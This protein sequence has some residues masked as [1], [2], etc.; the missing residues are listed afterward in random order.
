MQRVITIKN[1]TAED[2]DAEA[3]NSGRYNTSKP[4]K[5][6]HGFG[7]RNIRKTVEKYGGMLSFACEDKEF[8]LTIM[9]M[10]YNNQQGAATIAAPCLYAAERIYSMYF[11]AI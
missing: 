11:K 6:H 5:E 7:V 10:K 9:L 2:V 4:D 3:P 1:P 8:I